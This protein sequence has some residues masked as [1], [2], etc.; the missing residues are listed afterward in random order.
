MEE[1]AKQRELWL[2]NLWNLVP[3]EEEGGITR[4]ELAKR[5]GYNIE[6]RTE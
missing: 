3:L 6:N 1:Y 5:W 2:K 4:K